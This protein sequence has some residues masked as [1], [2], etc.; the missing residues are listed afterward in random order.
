[1]KTLRGRLLA[2]A[3]HLQVTRK[4]GKGQSESIHK[5]YMQHRAPLLSWLHLRKPGAFKWY[6]VR[7]MSERVRAALLHGCCLPV[8][9]VRKSQRRSRTPLLPVV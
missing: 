5:S 4:S 2:L 3:D 6:R 1:M 7:L 8:V 9:M